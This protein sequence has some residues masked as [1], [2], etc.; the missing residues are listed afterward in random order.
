MMKILHLSDLHYG[1]LLAKPGETGNVAMR[2][3]AHAFIG[4]DGKPDPLWLVH[5]L[6]GQEKD[7]LG[8]PDAVV[9]SGDVGWS[10]H[11]SDYAYA[12][13]FL[14]SLKSHWPDAAFILA[15]GNHDVSRALSKEGKNAQGPAIDFLRDFYGEDKFAQAYLCGGDVATE[16]IN[17][18]LVASVIETKQAIFVTANSAAALDH[19]NEDYP[20]YVS[21]EALLQLSPRLN[22]GPSKQ[23]KIRIFVMHHH[24]LPF[25]EVYKGPTVIPTEIASGQDETTIANSAQLQSWLAKNGFDL[26]LHGHRHESHTRLDI[27]KT[28]TEDSERRLIVAGAGSASVYEVGLPRRQ[29]H[30]YGIISVSA[31][32]RRRWAVRV[33]TR[34]IDSR[35]VI[36]PSTDYYFYE[37][38]G[39][40][41]ASLPAVF[42]AQDWHQVHEAIATTC[43][44]LGIPLTDPGKR[45]LLRNF[46][47]VIEQPGRLSE[48]D[49]SWNVPPTARSG[50]NEL[51]RDAV[52]QAFR[53]LHPEYGASK[54][55]RVKYRIPEALRS[56]HPH[57][58]FRHGARLFWSEPGRDLSESPLMRAAANIKAYKTRAYASTVRQDIDFV[59]NATEP[60][61]SLTSVQ[62]VDNLGAI[63][64]VA[65]FRNLELSYWWIV[66]VVEL[67]RLLYWAVEASGESGLKAGKIVITSPVV[68]WRWDPQSPGSADIDEQSLADTAEFVSKLGAGDRMEYARLEELLT[69][70]LQNTNQFNLDDRGI[71]RLGDLLKAQPGPICDL[72]TSL[73]MVADDIRMAIREASLRPYYTDS[74]KRRL[75]QTIVKLKTF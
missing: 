74:A 6:C 21:P 3:S 42:C 10:G 51:K 31:G 25:V 69:E 8:A 41:S 20:A 11:P 46:V 58:H 71:G 28:A 2:S 65:S 27:L 14:T 26:V 19:I 70:K 34:K 35:V 1:L 39:L 48:E 37:E 55:W 54:A 43:W 49:T 45:P 68:D 44:P 62:F 23:D 16:K 63:D 75:E 36:Q 53:A 13:T 52:E 61:P 4:K 7:H 29:H 66:N 18:H 64:L 17:R 60:M 57:F 12:K 33:D 24:L 30:S 73:I 32:A 40:Q 47:C 67:A 50:G 15:L 59:V 38:V 56:Q 5:I 9:I 22:F 72:S